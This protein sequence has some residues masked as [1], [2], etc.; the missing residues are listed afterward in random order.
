MVRAHSSL[1]A[2][3]PLAISP[4]KV[5]YLAVKAR[6]FSVKDDEADPDPTSELPD[7]MAYAVLRDNREDP[8]LA[9]M[10][11]FIASLSEDEQIDL[12][13]IAWLGRGDGALSDWPEL[14]REAARAHNARTADYLVGDPLL[15]D[16]LEE[17]LA[18]LG[19]SCDG[20]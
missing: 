9:E 10:A 15:A 13:A 11:A 7:E 14:R 17:G 6:Q 8:V 12:V 19:R 16:H 4:E 18:Q 1:P 5:C 20:F 3:P 2:T